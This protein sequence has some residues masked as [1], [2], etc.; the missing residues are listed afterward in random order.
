MGVARKEYTVMEDV[1]TTRV[2]SN[3]EICT[4]TAKTE[5]VVASLRMRENVSARFISS[6]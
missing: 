4:C 5:V 6:E 3:R 2:A 1:S